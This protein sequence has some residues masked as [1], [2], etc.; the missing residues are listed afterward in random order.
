MQYDPSILLRSFLSRAYSAVVPYG[1]QA[2]EALA[3]GWGVG[4]GGD[5]AED[6][7]MCLQI[8][9]IPYISRNAGSGFIG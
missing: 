7:Y 4:V 3:G 1:L 8:R 9:V 2:A 5:E 6:D